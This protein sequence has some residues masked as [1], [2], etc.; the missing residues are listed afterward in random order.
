[1]RFTR[2]GALDRFRRCAATSS[3]IFALT[4][5]SVVACGDDGGSPAVD[6]KLPHVNPATCTVSTADFG[7]KGTLTGASTY[8]AS[9]ADPAVGGI[10][11]V[12]P[13]SRR[14]TAM[15]GSSLE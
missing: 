10:T 1:M 7:A 13:A 11:L 4:S 6:A 14:R 9:M 12:A 15:I 2:A 8:R 3:F 5:L